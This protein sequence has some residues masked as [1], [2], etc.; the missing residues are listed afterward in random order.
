VSFPFPGD[1]DFAHSAENVMATFCHS[2]FFFTSR[3]S[4]ERW[5]STHE[6]TILYSLDE[7]YQMGRRLVSRQFGLE[8]DRLSRHRADV[9]GSIL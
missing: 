3:E 1:G 8:L 4:G 9:S 6:G 7:A 2:V 5:R